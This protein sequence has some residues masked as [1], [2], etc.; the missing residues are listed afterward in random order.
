MPE[1]P[2][3]GSG[4]NLHGVRIP[5]TR[6]DIRHELDQVRALQRDDS[7]GWFDRKRPGYG[8]TVRCPG[9][10]VRKEGITCW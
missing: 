6:A 1:L 3:D 8:P 9:S 2:A 10:L 7:G 4:L 5:S